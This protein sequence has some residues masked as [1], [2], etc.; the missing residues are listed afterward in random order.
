[1]TT[2][3]TY[4]ERNRDIQ[5]IMERH[6][7][8][9][10]K[11]TEAGAMLTVRGTGTRDEMVPVLNFGYS[12]N[13]TANYNTEVFT[14]ADGSDTAQKFALPTLPRDKQR[15]WK[16][17]AGGVQNPTD[18]TKA[19]EFNDKRTH[20][21]EDAFAV[22]LQGAIEVK[23]GVLYVRIPVVFA[24]DLQVNGAVTTGALFRGPGIP[25]G[26]SVQIPEWEE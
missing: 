18:A 2:D 14:L 6:V 4:G 5:D 23:D 15:R 12:F 26:G 22:G 9:S 11:Y 1:M 8:G 10:L 3:R 24:Q 7:W 25:V 20:I 19:L 17:G 16:E 13:V 21:T